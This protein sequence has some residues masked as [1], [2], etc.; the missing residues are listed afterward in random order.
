MNLKKFMTENYKPT[1]YDLKRRE[2][3]ADS[4]VNKIYQEF[5][6]PYQ[7]GKLLGTVL[8]AGTPV[9]PGI[10]KWIENLENGQ[11]KTDRILSYV[12]AKETLSSFEEFLVNRGIRA[13]DFNNYMKKHSMENNLTKSTILDCLKDLKKVKK[14][15]DAIEEAVEKCKKAKKQE[16]EE[17]DS[18][19]ILKYM[20]KGKKEEKE[21]KKEDS[22]PK[23]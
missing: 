5:S 6:T 15:T 22:K 10:R 1:S 23:K 3:Y 4:D 20:V 17:N 13:N 2:K 18:Q 21:K 12:E 11:K 14:E 7:P 8:R 16:D 9:S 19:N